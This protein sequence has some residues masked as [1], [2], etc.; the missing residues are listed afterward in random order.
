MYVSVFVCKN[1]V[2]TV[3][4]YMKQNPTDSQVLRFVKSSFYRHVY[5]IKIFE[6]FTPEYVHELYYF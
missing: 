3:N 1:D 4:E 6:F 2:Y 5:W